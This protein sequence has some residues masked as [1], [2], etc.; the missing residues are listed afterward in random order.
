MQRQFWCLIALCY[1]GL[2][3]VGQTAQAQP[4]NLNPGL[5]EYTNEL[6]FDNADEPQTQ[7][8]ESCVTEA[9]LAS[10][11][12][13]QQDIEACEMTEQRLQP[14]QMIYSMTC[15]GPE[16]T[17]LDIEADIE[18]N[19]DNASG[20]IN[21]TVLTPAGELSMTVNLTARRVGPCPDPRQD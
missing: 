4:L 8:F 5:W 7:V 11:Q 14:N 15:Q 6:R 10:G 18:L 12:F 16:G 20:V 21:N 9:D 1:L 17:S 19:G 3:L 13:M 2:G